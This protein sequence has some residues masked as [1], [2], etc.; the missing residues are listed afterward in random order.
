MRTAESAEHGVFCGVPAIIGRSGVK[1]IVQV[2][3]TEQEQAK[4]HASTDVIR[5]YVKDL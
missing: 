4:F 3:L 5:S 1:E 2:P